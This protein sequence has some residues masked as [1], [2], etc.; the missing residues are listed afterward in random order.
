MLDAIEYALSPR[1]SLDF[2]E[3][4]FYLGNIENPFEIIAT[5]EQVPDCLLTDDKY[6]CLMRGWHPSDGI[7]D[8][9]QE[10]DE[11]VLIP[12]PFK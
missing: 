11:L 5:V 9:P 3:C 7:H 2:K 8:E 4:G 6:G 1:W 10:G 12:M